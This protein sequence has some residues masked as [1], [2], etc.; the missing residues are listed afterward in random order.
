MED[1]LALVL[2][3]AVAILASVV[4]WLS[5]NSY[6]M[7]RIE[8]ERKQAIKKSA[9]VRAGQFAE[10]IAPYLPDFPFNP[11][12]ARFIGKPVDFIVFKGACEK[13]IEEV[14]FVEVKSGKSKV[15]PQEKRLRDVINEKRIRWYEYR[16]LSPE[17]SSNP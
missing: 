10:Q 17:S 16:A 7:K 12:D 13:E 5:M 4:V 11:A 9:E 2:I 14:I 8:D 15:S 1:I 3:V 6:W